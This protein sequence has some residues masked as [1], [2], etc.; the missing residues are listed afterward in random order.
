RL[1]ENRTVICVAHRLSTLAACD[2]IIVLANGGVVERGG[3]DELLQ[4]RG[5]FASMARKQGIMPRG[6]NAAA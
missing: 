4:S 3:F 5:V 1:S 6:G 2:E